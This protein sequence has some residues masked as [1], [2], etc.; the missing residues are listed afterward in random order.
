MFV[1]LVRRHFFLNASKE[2][3]LGASELEISGKT[4]VNIIYLQSFAQLL[5]SIW[6]VDSS[7]IINVMKTCFFFYVYYIQV[8]LI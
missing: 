1:F 7:S 6:L 5:N 8:L 3:E 2:K 4:G